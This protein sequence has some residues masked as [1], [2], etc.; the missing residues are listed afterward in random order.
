[1]TARSDFFS[2]LFSDHF[3]EQDTSS[4][5]F[6][7]HGISDT[8]LDCLALY[9]YCEKISENLEADDHEELLQLSDF[10]MLPGLKKLLASSMAKLLTVDNCISWLLRGKIKFFNPLDEVY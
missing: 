7:L 2:G 6:P 5:N 4:E 3:H 9:V 8:A 1:M 10:Y